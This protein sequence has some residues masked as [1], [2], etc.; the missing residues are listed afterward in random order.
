MMVEALV[1]NDQ[2]RHTSAWMRT[3]MNYNGLSKGMNGAAPQTSDPNFSGQQPNWGTYYNGVYL[4]WR[5]PRAFTHGVQDSVSGITTYPQVPN[6]YPLEAGMLC[7]S[8][9]L[10]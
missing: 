6:W 9:E 10:V 3:T 4:K 2:T 5:L 8:H 7:G 1:V